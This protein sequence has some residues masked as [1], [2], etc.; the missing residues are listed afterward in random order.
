MFMNLPNRLSMIVRAV[1]CAAIGLMMVACSS[2][3]NQADTGAK[4]SKVK[5]YAMTNFAP[6]PSADPSIPFERDYHL[7]GAVTNAQRQA[8]QG[9]YYAVMWKVTD[10]T[11]PVKVRLEYRQQGTGLAVKTKETDVSALDKSNV[12]RFAVIGDEFANNGPV[13]AWRVSLVRGKQ[14]LAESKSYLW[15]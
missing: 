2:P 10:R 15:D 8:R 5:Y 9:N 1:A 3:S 14:V 13:T 11:Q 4:I 12:T 6:V 7:Y